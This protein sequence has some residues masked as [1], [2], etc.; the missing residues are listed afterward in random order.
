MKRGESFRSWQCDEFSF[1]EKT[2]AIGFSRNSFQR[3]FTERRRW[4]SKS[5]EHTRKRL[6]EIAIEGGRRIRRDWTISRRW[7]LSLQPE[8]HTMCEEEEDNKR[9]RSLKLS[10]QA[11]RGARLIRVKSVSWFRSCYLPIHRSISY[12]STEARWIVEIFRV[13][14]QNLLLNFFLSLF[15]LQFMIW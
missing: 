6:A 10:C 4:L 5:L 9:N 2:R 3:R 12:F 8:I 7:N 13:Q 14:R 1:E 11:A 15:F